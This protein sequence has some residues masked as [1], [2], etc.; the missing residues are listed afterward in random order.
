MAETQR[1]KRTEIPLVTQFAIVSS[2]LKHRELATKHG[3]DRSTVTKLF[4]RKAEIE[5]KWAENGPSDRKRNR[6]GK[7]DD[8]DTSVYDWFCQ[9]IQSYP[10]I[11]GGMVQRCAIKLAQKMNIEG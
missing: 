6:K 7:H 10:R 8:L 4:K 11:N 9:K 5:K 3:L 1:K 2:N